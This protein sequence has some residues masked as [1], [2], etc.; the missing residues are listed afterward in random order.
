[1]R[2][3]SKL[4]LVQRLTYKSTV[5]PAHISVKKVSRRR[6][7]PQ[8][9]DHKDVVRMFLFSLPIEK[10]STEAWGGGDGKGH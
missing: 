4:S 7:L 10:V 8:V 3:E 6:H 5:S 1:V 9:S 2:K